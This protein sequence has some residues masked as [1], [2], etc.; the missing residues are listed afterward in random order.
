MPKIGN[1]SFKM[2]PC[3]CKGLPYFSNFSSH[4]VISNVNFCFVQHHFYCSQQLS[5][6]EDEFDSNGEEDDPDFC[7]LNEGE[8]EDSD[9]NSESDMEEHSPKRRKLSHHDKRGPA[10]QE[11]E[12]TVTKQN[13]PVKKESFAAMISKISGPVFDFSEPKSNSNDPSKYISL[14]KI[15]KKYAKFWWR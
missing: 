2:L 8:V 6:I 11:K 4:K 3:T 7:V 9:L 1:K 10:K 13:S 15:R 5:S 14:L 12:E